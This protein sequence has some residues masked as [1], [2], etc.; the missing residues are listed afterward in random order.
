[1]LLLLILKLRVNPMSPDEYEGKA[2]KVIGIALGVA[3]EIF[4]HEEFPRPRWR[5]EELVARGEYYRV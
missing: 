5:F 2:S 4:V 3:G 1:M